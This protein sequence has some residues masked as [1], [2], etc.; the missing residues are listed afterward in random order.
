MGTLRWLLHSGVRLR[1]GRVVPARV[2]GE[3]EAD[4]PGQG[5]AKTLPDTTPCALEG[6]WRGLHRPREGG[7]CSRDADLGRDAARRQA[8]KAGWETIDLPE[9]GV[10]ILSGACC[11][12]GW[13]GVRRIFKARSTKL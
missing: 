4:K 2:A 7:P 8:F 9:C 6:E 10:G 12:R 1:A 5:E 11:H 3:T 13:L